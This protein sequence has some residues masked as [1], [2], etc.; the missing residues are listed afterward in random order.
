VRGDL[1]PPHLPGHRS[2]AD[3]FDDLVLDSVERLSRRWERELAAVDVAVEEVPAHDPPPG[4]PV[5]TGRTEP[6]GPGRRARL[7]LHRR[8]LVD[9]S[10][11]D[12]PRAVH[13][14]VVEQLAALLAR[15][16]EEV[17]P[18]LPDDD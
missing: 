8:P 17:D 14:A 9:R 7:V 18:D 6:A 15:T 5:A 3:R 13:L 2:P 12:L 11:D 10:G 16:P 4:S 1:L